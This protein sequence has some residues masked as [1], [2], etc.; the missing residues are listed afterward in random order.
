[1]DHKLLAYR[2]EGLG[3]QPTADSTTQ[4]EDIISQVIGVLS[5]VAVIWFAF[6]VIFAGYAYMSSQGDK[7]KLETARKRLTQGILGL[8]ISLIAIF[9]AA[10]IATLAG[11]DGIF[12]LNQQFSNMGL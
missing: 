5:V 1:M 8:V 10:L 9:L 11:F 4:L 12:D 6:Q 7:T 2:L 3:V